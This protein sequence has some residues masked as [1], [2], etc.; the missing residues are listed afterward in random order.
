LKPGRSRRSLARVEG[1]RRRIEGAEAIGAALSRG[2]PLRLI[3]VDEAVE[4]EAAA[5]ALFEPARVAGVPVQTVG[6]RHF[7]RLC[8]PDGPG[9][10]VALLGATPAC[11]ASEV[12]AR[13][14]PAWLLTGVV[15]PGNAGFAIRT[16]EVSGAAGVFLDCAFDHAQRREALRASMR[17]DRFLPVLWEP[18]AAVLT[19]ARGAGRRVVGVEDVGGRPPWQADLTGPVLFVVGGEAD[20]VPAAVLERCDV[21][22]RLPM[23]GF[24]R[25]YNLQAAVAAVAAERL[26]Q[27]EAPAR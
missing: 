14:G 20:G 11:D 24:I 12:L 18:A 27:Q 10:A 1:G 15:Y 16:A 2:E 25:S 7:E 3:V 19:A 23:A 17:A 21:V 8:P 9:G 6:T 22:V 4:A 13:E 26:R 5:Q